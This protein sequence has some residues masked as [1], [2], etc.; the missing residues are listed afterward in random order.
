MISRFSYLNLHEAKEIPGTEMA[1]RWNLLAQWAFSALPSP[2]HSLRRITPSCATDV[3]ITIR[4]IVD[5][6]PRR[7]IATPVQVP[8]TSGCLHMSRRQLGASWRHHAGPVT[9]PSRPVFRN[10]VFVIF[11][12]VPLPTSAATVM[13]GVVEKGIPVHIRDRVLSFS[14]LLSARVR[15]ARR[16]HSFTVGDIHL[17]HG[18]MGRD[19]GRST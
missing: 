9:L 18:Q 4:I 11:A 3:L 10:R 15:S 19:R 16:S 14:V 5:G 1:A 2:F 12:G 17:G 8:L 6:I 13:I 7:A